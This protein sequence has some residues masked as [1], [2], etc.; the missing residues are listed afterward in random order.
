MAD[1]CNGLISSQDYA[2]EIIIDKC[3][4][5]KAYARSV[6]KIFLTFKK[7]KPHLKQISTIS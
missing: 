4:V 3:K 5:S 2:I 6:F 7:N 1:Y